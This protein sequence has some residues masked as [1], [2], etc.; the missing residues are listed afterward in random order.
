MKNHIPQ[1]SKYQVTVDVTDAAP[2]H[3]RYAGVLTL[4]QAWHRF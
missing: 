1:E 3:T 4:K 2:P